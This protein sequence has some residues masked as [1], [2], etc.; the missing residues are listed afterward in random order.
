MLLFYVRHGDPCYN[1]DSLTPLGHR[2]AEAIGRRLAR[3]GV[4][5][6]YASTMVRATQ[7]AMPTAELLKKEIRPVE[8]ARED[9]AW[10][11]LSLVSA[12]GRRRWVF[13]DPDTKKL[14][15]TPEVRV[16]GAEWYNHPA[17]EGT[18]YRAGVE[19]IER[20]TDAWLSSLGWEHA[21]RDGFYRHTFAGP[22]RV[23]LFA[24]QGFG[25]FF[26]SHILGMSYPQFSVTFD[27]SHTSLT[28]IE[29][30]E[31][32]DVCIPCVYTMANDAH[33]YREDLPIYT[34]PVF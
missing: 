6:I 13:S 31:T 23:A 4:D 12:D 7:T 21:G 2:Q 25:T 27:I 11:M 33:L 5:E 1:P 29:F 30:D 34:R 19:R 20:E 24:H 9:R 14:F 32:Q 18:T 22:Q 28:V 17:F 16:L 8:F 10:D 15:A 26:L 3:Y